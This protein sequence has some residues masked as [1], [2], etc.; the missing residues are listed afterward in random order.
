MKHTIPH[1]PFTARLSGSAKEIELRLCNIFRWKKKRPP[2]LLLLAALLMAVGCG[3]LVSCQPQQKAPPVDSSISVDDPFKPADGSLAQDKS[4]GTLSAANDN[5]AVLDI[6]DAIF[7]SQT[8]MQCFLFPGT[9]PTVVPMD[10]YADEVH[11]IFARYTWTLQDEKTYREAA[12]GGWTLYLNSQGSS[13]IRYNIAARSDSAWIEIMSSGAGSET[14]W[15]SFEGDPGDL[16][17]SLTDIWDGPEIRYALV[18]LP[19]DINGAQ[20]LAEAYADAFREMYLSSGSIT[21]FELQDL[22][23]LPRENGEGNYSPFQIT[24]SVKPADPEAPYWEYEPPAEDGWVT[25]SFEMYL[26]VTEGVWRCV[27][28]EPI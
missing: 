27:W 20:A 22:A 5:Q 7:E 18:T 16:V 14:F 28:W 12:P 2:V 26:Y 17:Q 25:F 11:E 13:H 10:G 19:E 3:S 1:T 8:Y 21:D 23:V 24:Y 15:Y 6:V 9:G 4:E